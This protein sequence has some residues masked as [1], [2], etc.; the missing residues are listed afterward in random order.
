MFICPVCY[1][2][3]LQESPMDYNI[4]ECC[5][6]EFGVDDDD[7]TVD[8]LRADWIV[9]GCPWF[10]GNPPLGWNAWIQLFSG[11]ALIPDYIA[12]TS[13]SGSGSWS[14]SEQQ[15]NDDCFAQLI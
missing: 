9:R 3:K 14:I 5:G 7:W 8:E 12:G 10:F 6:T 15:V 2:D 4:C 1:Y 11:Y 13:L